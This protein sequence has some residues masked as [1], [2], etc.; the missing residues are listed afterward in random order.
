MRLFVNDKVKA[1]VDKLGMDDDMPIEAKMLTK[2]I[3]GAQKKVEARNFGIR[4]HVLQY[5]DVMNRQREIIYTERQKVLQGDNL[6]EQIWGM[7]EAYVDDSIALYTAESSFAEE[8]DLGKLQDHLQPVF[9]PKGS[10]DFTNTEELTR[11]Q[12]REDLLK[13]GETIYNMKEA[14]IGA[15]RMREIERVV[16]LRVVDSKWIDHIDAMDQLKQGVGLRA[17]GNEDPVRAYQIEG[18]D[19]FNEMTKFIQEDM[20]KYLFHVTIETDTKREKVA[21]ITGTGRQSAR[22]IKKPQK[23]EEPKVGR[24][25]PCPCGS[26]KKYKN[27]MELM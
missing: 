2:S 10:V 3:E 14:E 1:M 25:E 20:L 18:F 13:V 24:N 23:R 17:V 26:G 21:K 6:R 8:W 19:M 7:L 9:L 16:L 12:I 5:D 22:K 11:E 15:E 4:K 27:A